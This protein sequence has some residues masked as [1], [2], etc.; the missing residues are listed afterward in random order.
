MRLVAKPPPATARLGLRW[1]DGASTARG[2]AEPILLV[3]RFMGP[4]PSVHLGVHTPR[5]LRHSSDSSDTG[6][7]NELAK[8]CVR[9]LSP[10]ALKSLGPLAHVGSTPTPGTNVFSYLQRMARSECKGRCPPRCPPRGSLLGRF[11]HPEGDPRVS[12]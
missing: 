1:G 4:K 6:K 2:P 10:V 3:P 8:S 7:G 9:C 11:L 12:L 5:T